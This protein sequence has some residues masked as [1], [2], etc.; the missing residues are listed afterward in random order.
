MERL[1]LYYSCTGKTRFLAEKLRDEL[2][3]DLVEIR[4]LKKRMMA[5]GEWWK[6]KP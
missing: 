5:C 2:G 1:I 6:E 4:D 3:A